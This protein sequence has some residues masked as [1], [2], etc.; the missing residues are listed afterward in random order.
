M[1][2][3]LSLLLLVATIIFLVKNKKTE[4][5]LMFVGQLISFLTAIIFKILGAL[6]VYGSIFY[7]INHWIYVIGT[8]IF[9]AGVFVLAFNTTIKLEPAEEEYNRRVQNNKKDE[10]NDFITKKKDF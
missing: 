8:L 5:I 7:S 2:I 1:N 10:G 4:S 6:S 3:F 9:I